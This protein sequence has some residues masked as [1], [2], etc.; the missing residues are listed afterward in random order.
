[1]IMMSTL[2]TVFFFL[3]WFPLQWCCI[4]WEGGWWCCGRWCCNYSNNRCFIPLYNHHTSFI[5]YCPRS[6]T[7]LFIRSPSPPPNNY[8]HLSALS[9]HQ[10]TWNVYSQL[11]FRYR[12]LKC[13]TGQMARDWV[14]WIKRR[15]LRDKVSDCKW[16]G[17]KEFLHSETCGSLECSTSN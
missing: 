11:S 17:L 15:N 14:P 8:S 2:V 3:Y 13:L 7:D 9:E 10:E 4:C 12:N 1:M 6:I 5:S 16:W